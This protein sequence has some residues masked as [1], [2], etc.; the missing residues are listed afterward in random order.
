MDI[1][2]IWNTGAFWMANFWDNLVRGVEFIMPPYRRPYVYQP[3][4]PEPIGDSSDG[5][6]PC[7]YEEL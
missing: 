5:I 1:E 7:G 4:S 6:A 2:D 3:S